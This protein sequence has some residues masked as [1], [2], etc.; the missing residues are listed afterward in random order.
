MDPTKLA[1]SSMS[2]SHAVEG[3]RFIEYD[4]T[5][6]KLPVNFEIADLP[7]IGEMK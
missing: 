2:L 3:L 5:P 1:D 6:P 7:Y 4:A